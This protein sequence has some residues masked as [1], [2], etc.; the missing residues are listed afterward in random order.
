MI[1]LICGIKVSH[2]AGIDVN[3]DGEVLFMIE[4]EKLDNNHRYSSLGDLWRVAQILKSEGLDPTDIDQF[5]VDGW[6]VEGVDDTEV[7]D[8][9][10]LAARGGGRLP[11]PV[12]PYHDPQGGSPLAPSSFDDHAFSTSTL[13]Y[14]SYPHV[15]N[16]LLGGIL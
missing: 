11:I 14:P 3:H 6:F 2:D 10:V 4:I 15:S 7:T 13:H 1:M 5:V 9:A 12:A 8:P 16:H